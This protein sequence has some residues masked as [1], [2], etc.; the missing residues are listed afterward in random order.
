MKWTR[1]LT[2]CAL[3]AA[4]LAVASPAYAQTCDLDD[5]SCSEPDD[6]G[7]IGGF[8]QNAVEGLAEAFREGS[9]FVIETVSAFWIQIDS[10]NL[11]SSPVDK[12]RDVTMPLVYVIATCGVLW[13]GIR[14]AIR[15][16]KE[17]MWDI[18]T[19]LARLAIVNAIYVIAPNTLLKGV[20]E[21]AK[22]VLDQAVGGNVVERFT[23]LASLGGITSPAAIIIVALFMML[24]GAIQAMLM[25]LR[26]GGI[27]ILSAM[28]VLAASGGLNP[29]TKSWFPRVSGW[30]LALIA[31]KLVAAM[32]FA[33]AF[34]MI[35]DGEG[36]RQIIV[37][38]TM[39]GLSVV[40]LPAMM[41][42]FTWAV[43]G[44]VSSGGGAGM[45]GIAGAGVAALAM[46]GGAGGGVV[47][48]GGAGAQAL[49]IER[50][51]GPSGATGAVP[52]GPVSM[53]GVS[54]AG[55]GAAPASAAAG[56]RAAAAAAGPAAAATVVAGQAAVQ[57]AQAARSKAV[58][59]MTGDME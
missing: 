48:S 23:Q 17:P 33:A 56:G 3:L 50:D 29:T 22:W 51:L 58:K 19:G 38:F 5:P 28:L 12:L 14:I 52:A 53:G 59:G 7:I 2:C 36:L 6:G 15:R 18:G 47:T 44:A 42:F 4:V 10:I 39:L 25:F 30:L 24:V 57:A 11:A 8:V 21:M 9:E 49:R 34:F 43:P 31:Y 40:A 35:G 16:N 41:K 32:C 20:D 26:E 27:V 37:G 45:A 1:R 13:G 54:A 55:G 46:R